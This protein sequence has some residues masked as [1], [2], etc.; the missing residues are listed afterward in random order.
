VLEAAANLAQRGVITHVEFC[1]TASAARRGRRAAGPAGAQGPPGPVNVI[2]AESD[3]IPLPH[4]SAATGVAVCPQ[5]TVVIGG[6]VVQLPPVGTPQTGVS[7]R[8]SDWDT[9][10]GDVPDEWSVTMDNANTTNDQNFVVDA[11]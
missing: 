10:T 5:G 7:V 1:F 9:A 4:Q 11:K 8:F 6:G 3:T 2:Y